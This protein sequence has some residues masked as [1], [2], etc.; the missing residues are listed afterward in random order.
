MKKE[1]L[2]D[3]WKC[4]GLLI[5]GLLVAVIIYPVLHES[6]HIIV[7]LA[8]GGRIVDADLFPVPNVL[9]EVSE[10]GAAGM[11]MIGFGGMVLP[12]AISTTIPRKWFWSWYVRFLIKAIGIW[13]FCVSII[14][15]CYKGYGGIWIQDDMVVVNNYWKYGKDTLIIILI[16]L[17][18]GVLIS[19]IKEKPIYRICSEFGI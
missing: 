10:V 1:L 16:I 9:C 13:A 19:L 7:S 5:I 3:I 6:G 11:V 14:A 4:I 12:L 15:L 8:V 18:L 17:C 2:F